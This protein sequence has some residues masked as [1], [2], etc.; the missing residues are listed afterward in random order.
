MDKDAAATRCL[1][2]RRPLGDVPLLAVLHREGLAHICPECLPVLIH[3]P[4]T[5]ADRLPGADALKP[6]G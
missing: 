1:N 6:K 2:C 5:L 4:Q 3:E